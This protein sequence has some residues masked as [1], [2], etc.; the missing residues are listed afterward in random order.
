MANFN[1]SIQPAQIEY[2]L[3]PGR[4]II[5]AYQIKNES[6][7]PL[8]LTTSI[9]A[10]Q[11]K[12]TDGS[13]SYDNVLLNPN[14][15]FS[16]NNSDLKLGESFTLQPNS[17]RQLVL[18]IKSNPSSAPSDTYATFFVTQNPGQIPGESQSQAVVKIGSHLLLTTST[19][20]K[21]ELKAEII[22]FKTFP[23]IK[24]IF[25]NQINFSA[26]IKNPTNFF[27]KTNGFISITKNNLEIKK[28]DL[29][30]LNV[31]SHSNRQ[32][33]CSYQTDT[34]SAKSSNCYLSP[35]FWPGQYTAT[36]TLSNNDA[37]FS[38]SISF[39]VFPY[40]FIITILIVISIIFS[41]FYIRKKRP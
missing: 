29:T 31:L 5:Q 22:N 3:Q 28:I 41:V 27:F 4:T 15:Q 34:P 24:D 30:S 6:G 20:A 9:E 11:P 14:L 33:Q 37:N 19:T 2:V 38:Q 12:N 16:L 36:L 40:A 10:W 23:K 39:F 17:E 8:I 26:E 25:L 35:P 21:P 13:V 18:K 7:N 32:I 1:V